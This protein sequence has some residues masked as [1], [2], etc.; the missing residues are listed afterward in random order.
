MGDHDK[1]FGG[2]CRRAALAGVLGM[3]AGCAEQAPQQPR[4]EVVAANWPAPRPVVVHR[5]PP[6]Q[7]AKHKPGSPTREESTTPR[8]EEVGPAE[9]PAEVAAAPEQMA[10]VP[11]TN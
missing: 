11:S 3:L 5:R 4:T 2:I 9:P 7:Q 6:A 1:R 10:A 8:R